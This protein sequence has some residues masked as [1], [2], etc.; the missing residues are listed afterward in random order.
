MKKRP[1]YGLLAEFDNSEELVAAARRAHAEGYRR[2]DAFTPLPVEGLAEAIGFHRT[3][4]PLVVLIG[5]IVGCVSGFFLQYYP[6]VISFPLNIA[7][8]PNNSWPAFIPITFEMTVLGAA[9]AAVFGMLAMNGLPTPYHPV[10]NVP[11]FAL[12]TRDRFFLCIKARDPK[13]DLTITK[14]FLT[15]LRALGVFEIEA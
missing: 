8:K 9:L 14:E 10:F 5:G 11:R 2:L 13:F 12:A 3:N 7:G 15:G 6:N 4:L 1:I